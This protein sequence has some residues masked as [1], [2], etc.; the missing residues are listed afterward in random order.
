MQDLTAP[1]EDMACLTDTWCYKGKISS[2]LRIKL[3]DFDTGWAQNE[4][5]K[6]PG[7]GELKKIANFQL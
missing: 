6:F 3:K 4:Q 7:K 5:A 2:N 1:L